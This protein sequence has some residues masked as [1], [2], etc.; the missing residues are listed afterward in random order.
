[1]TPSMS[2]LEKHNTRKKT[3][4][5]IITDYT[6]NKTN[7]HKSNGIIAKFS[8]PVLVP[9]KLLLNTEPE[10]I[11]KRSI[12][13]EERRNLN[14]VAK[15]G[16]LLIKPLTTDPVKSVTERRSPGTEPF[17][18]LIKGSV[19][20]PAINDSQKNTDINNKS[21]PRSFVK[22]R[23]RSLSISIGN[24][25][26]DSRTEDIL[27]YVSLPEEVVNMNATKF[28]FEQ[29][30]HDLSLMKRHDANPNYMKEKSQM[31]YLEEQ[32]ETLIKVLF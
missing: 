15:K 20:L 27:P 21:K 2:L 4:I 9:S 16:S 18:A 19:V 30:I 22:P 17:G 26:T 5:D 28:N 6:A 25:A 13:N 31:Q 8:K 14:M 10:F 23:K 1:M 29:Y 24:D 11:L 3:L 7:P 12:I 32:Y